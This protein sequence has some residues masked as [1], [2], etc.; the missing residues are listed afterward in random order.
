MQ[1]ERKQPS[2]R[3]ARAAWLHGTVAASP[4]S[5]VVRGCNN[6]QK[7]YKHQTKQERGEA[8]IQVND[9]LASIATCKIN[10][11]ETLH[12]HSGL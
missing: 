10:K 11:K 2:V 1:P 12:H 3:E 6:R 5:A 8:V 9:E 7:S 4:A